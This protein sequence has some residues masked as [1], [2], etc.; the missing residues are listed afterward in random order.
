MRAG[1]LVEQEELL[2]YEYFFIIANGGRGFPGL[3]STQPI[4]SKRHRL[5]CELSPSLLYFKLNGYVP[6][7]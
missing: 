7:E 2:V 3:F 6:L 1:I 5:G 4:L